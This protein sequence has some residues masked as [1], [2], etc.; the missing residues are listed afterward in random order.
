MSR[1]RAARDAALAHALAEHHDAVERQLTANLASLSD[2]VRPLQGPPP[3]EPAEVAHTLAAGILTLG[4]G[5]SLTVTRGDGQTTERWTVSIT[6][7]PEP[8]LAA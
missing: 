2:S 7:N 8:P 5:E 6:T 1:L 3:P 4:P